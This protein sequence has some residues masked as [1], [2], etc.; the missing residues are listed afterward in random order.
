[1]ETSEKKIKEKTEK[2]M[3]AF[4]ELSMGKEVG[5]F[6]GAVYKRLKKNR[7]FEAIKGLII[8]H[9]QK[10]DGN[11]DNSEKLLEL[12]EFRLRLLHLFDED[13][14]DTLEKNED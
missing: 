3:T 7:N 14:M 9:L 2:I 1:M 6:S 13:E 4:V 8:E 5:W 12:S 10:F 11:I